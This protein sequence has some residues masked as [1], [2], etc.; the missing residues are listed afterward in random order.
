LDASLASLA[1][2]PWALALLGLCIGSFLNVVVHRLP[3]MMERQWRADCAALSETDSAAIPPQDEPFN[4]VSPRSRCPHC[5]HL[6]T[7]Y[8]NI[9]VLS[10]LWLRGRCSACRG[11]ISMRYPLVELFTAGL[12]GLIAWRI[13][14]DLTVLVWLAVAA[15]LLTMA[16]I[17]WDTTLLPDDITL[18]LL[19]SGLIA[20]ALGWTVSLESAVWG[21][22]AGYLALW[23]VY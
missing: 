18:P 23:L 17:D 12:F 9:P 7:W 10:Y 16:L 11:G 5:G 8:E 6:I 14:A 22:I 19:W 20:A 2:S 15:A 1:L 4:L 21:A 13:G 3:Q